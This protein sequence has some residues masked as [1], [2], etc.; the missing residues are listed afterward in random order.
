MKK[1][2]NKPDQLVKSLDRALNILE[3]L[4]DIN[5]PLGITEISQYTGYHKSTVYRLIDTLCYRGYLTQDFET[6]KYK[7]GMK[8]FEI[9]S[10]VFNNLD[11]RSQVKPYL[12]EIEEK[13]AETVHLG[14]L[15][16]TK[17]VYIDKVESRRTIR[18]SSKIGSRTYAHSTGLGKAILAYLAEDEVEQII[19]E[20]GLPKFTENTITN[21]EELINE[22]EEIRKKGFAIDEEENETGIICVAA[23][24]FDYNDNIVAA[25]SISGP[26]NRMTNNKIIKI[27]D[28]A[29]EYSKLISRALGQ[30]NEK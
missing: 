22:L 16:S 23:P 26:A 2:K 1:N 12:K 20:E 3:K 29:R 25:I 6:G 27:K 24:I 19:E 9:G 28:I 4:V 11:L 18:M 13:T 30:R 17:M 14:V 21:K 10:E 5:E 7:V 8:L 15:D